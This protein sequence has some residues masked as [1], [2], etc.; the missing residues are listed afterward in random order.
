MV[1]T[2]AGQRE[3]PPQ[4]QE[5]AAD[6]PRPLC[7]RLCVGFDP[8]GGNRV[9]ASLVTNHRH[10]S[11]LWPSSD[12]TGDGHSI[13]S[14]VTNPEASAESSAQATG[15]RFVVPHLCGSGGQLPSRIA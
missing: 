12:A 8:T 11:K 5:F 4:T 2:N 7:R 1:K 14:A 10:D 9:S 3:A 6:H 13:C 15:L